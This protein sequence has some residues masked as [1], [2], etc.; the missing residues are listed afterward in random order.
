[1]ASCAGGWCAGCWWC[2]CQ[3]RVRR[4]L[5]SASCSRLLECMQRARV[6][7]PRRRQ[8]RCCQRR[9]MSSGTRQLAAALC[10]RLAHDGCR[11]PLLVAA[12]R[13][14]R[15]APTSGGGGGLLR[16]GAASCA[17]CG[18]HGPARIACSLRPS[19]RAI[20]GPAERGRHLGAAACAR[21]QDRHASS[22]ARQRSIASPTF[23]P[24]PTA[25]QGAQGGRRAGPQPAATMRA[26]QVFSPLARWIPEVEEPSGGK[27]VQFK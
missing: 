25:S 21:R 20:G 7:A 6:G 9:G 4:M 26:L 16:R 17:G 12:A 15:G 22:F 5:A 13:V 18:L 10:W 19:R 3:S 1:M 23:S 11:L 14:A 24:I 2:R 8:W 27:R